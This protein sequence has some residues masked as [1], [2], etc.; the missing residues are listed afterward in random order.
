MNI[1]TYAG[2]DKGTLYVYF[3]GKWRQ[4]KHLALMLKR[5]HVP[6]VSAVNLDN[7]RRLT[8]VVGSW[9]MTKAEWDAR[10]VTAGY[11]LFTQ[12][13]GSMHEHAWGD[14]TACTTCRVLLE[15]VVDALIRRP[16]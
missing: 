16:L 6:E 14:D 12:G 3:E 11:T 1:Y 15:D 8:F 4:D 5:R 2:F 10:R 13:P 7:G 9:D